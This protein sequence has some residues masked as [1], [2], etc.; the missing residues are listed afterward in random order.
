[1]KPGWSWVWAG[2]LLTGGVWSGYLWWV[3]RGMRGH[4]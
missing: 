1:M 2:Y 4:K 3:I